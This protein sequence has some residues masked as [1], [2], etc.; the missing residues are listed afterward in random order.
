M[1]A[2]KV[3]HHEIVQNRGNALDRATGLLAT[4]GVG[5]VLR[6]YYLILLVRAKQLRNCISSFRKSDVFLPVFPDLDILCFFFSHSHLIASSSTC[7][8]F[9]HSCVSFSCRDGNSVFR[10]LH[11]VETPALTT[12][13]STVNR[14]LPT[15]VRHDCFSLSY[16]HF[17]R[18]SSFQK[19]A[20]DRRKLQ[21]HFMDYSGLS[22]DF[23]G[24]RELDSF[25]IPRLHSNERAFLFYNFIRRN[26]PGVSFPLISQPPP[27]PTN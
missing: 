17:T 18:R 22:I 14:G 4:W 3:V 16:K 11:I 25:V 20:A 6:I 7:T 15:S 9:R 10:F 5:T 26:R 1:G 2:A 27:L 23:G 12:R 8:L 13:G 21:F 19:G 24:V